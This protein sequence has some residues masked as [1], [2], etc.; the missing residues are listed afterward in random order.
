MPAY[1]SM[2]GIAIVCGQWH[3]GVGTTNQPTLDS[4]GD[5]AADV[6][7]DVCNKDFDNDGQPD[8]C[9]TSDRAC[10]TPKKCFCPEP[11]PMPPPAPPPP[12]PPPSPPPP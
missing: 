7:E 4:D 5:G 6:C 9:V 11:P 10:N 1:G 12:V 8:G 3:N 2:A